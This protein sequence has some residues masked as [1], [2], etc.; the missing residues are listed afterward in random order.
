MVEI[1]ARTAGENQLVPVERTVDAIRSQI[2][3]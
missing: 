2:A 3:A 1:K